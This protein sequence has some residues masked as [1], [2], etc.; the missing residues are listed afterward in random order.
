MISIRD[1]LA[2]SFSFFRKWKLDRELDA[3]L[4]AHLEMAIED[5]MK[6]GMSAEEA[7]RSALISLGGMDAARELHRETRGLP[8]LETILQDV[9]YSFRTLRRDAGLATFAILIIGLGVSASSTVFSVVNALL[10]RPLPFED[11]DRLAWIANSSTPGL[12]GST[13]QVS[14]LLISPRSLLRGAALIC[15]GRFR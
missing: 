3:E 13:V 11:P 10:L 5:N 14:H 9:R 15:I 8:V 4:S 12:S 1:L 7:R 6:Q 2:R